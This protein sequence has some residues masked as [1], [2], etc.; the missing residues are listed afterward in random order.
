MHNHDK[1]KLI[2][3]F[4]EILQLSKLPGHISVRDY[5]Y[6]R[7]YD[8]VHSDSDRRMFVGSQL[9]LTLHRLVHEKSNHRFATDKCLFE[10]ILHKAGFPTPQTLCVY[11]KKSDPDSSEFYSVFTPKELQKWL[12]DA[13]L[14]PIFGKPRTG[15]R[16]VGVVALEAFEQEAN[17]IIAGNGRKVDISTLV[18]SIKRYRRKGYIFQKK[19]RS[20][21]KVSDI[22]EDK[23]TTVRLILLVNRERP[24]V[25]RAAWKLPANKNIADNFWRGNVLAGLNTET[26]EVV[27]AITGDGPAMRTITHHP[28]SDRQLLGTRVPDWKAL[29]SM[30]VDASQHIPGID[31]QAW[32]IA[33]TDSGPVLLEVNIG[34]DY[35]IPQLAVNKGMLEYEFIKFIKDCAKHR[36]SIKKTDRL[37]LEKIYEIVEQNMI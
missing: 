4:L 2:E 11:Q 17:Q 3:I 26:G 15:I 16:S 30:C 5:F 37:R 33:I 27:R 20:H 9:E 28:D 13:S 6:Y 25:Y 12:Q 22:I 34:G 14:Y 19:L 31:M 23:V 21:Q 18:K 29:I 7:L 36:T 32:D 10:N 8:P 24:S 35:C 1:T